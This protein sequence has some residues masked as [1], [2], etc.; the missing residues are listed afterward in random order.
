MSIKDSIKVI[1]IK[2]ET[3]KKKLADNKMSFNRFINTLG[4]I[5]LK[6]RVFLP[7]LLKFWRIE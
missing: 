4:G 2:A 1:Q 7:L 3:L 5:I 6:H